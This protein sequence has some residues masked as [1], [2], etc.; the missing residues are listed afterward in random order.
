MN[1]FQ[2][3]KTTFWI[4]VTLVPATATAV[5]EKQWNFKVYLDDREIGYHRF[6]LNNQGS[7]HY[8][9]SEA[10][11]KVRFLGIPLYSYRHDNRE[12]WNDQCLNEIAAST[13]DNG[14]EYRVDGTVN[15]NGFILETLKGKQLLPSCIST[16]SYWDKSI[17]ENNQLLNSQT[18]EYL[19][20]SSSFQ[21]REVIDA[22]NNKI[23][24][25]RYRL[26]NDKFNIDIWYS[27]NDEW[28]ALESITEGGRVLR[29]IIE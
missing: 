18:G 12:S 6:S 17:L 7:T 20:I 24:A 9:T 13:D 5:F 16:F 22:G 29:Y 2:L 1:L 26:V 21:G 28:L 25:L 27:E 14:K 10:R 15:E 4:V 23:P 19:D 11:F 8:V 3:V